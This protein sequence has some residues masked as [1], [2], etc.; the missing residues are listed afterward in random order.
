MF[1]MGLT[2][3]YQ[4]CVQVIIVYGTIEVTSQYTTECL[5]NPKCVNDGA[6]N[7]PLDMKSLGL[8]HQRQH[9]PH[10][11]HHHNIHAWL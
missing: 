9:E 6:A 5:N 11:C 1:K 3:M 7:T 2:A 4:Y 10:S 8:A